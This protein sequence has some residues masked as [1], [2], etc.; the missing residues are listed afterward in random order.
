[1]SVKC[2]V[3]VPYVFT[4][5]SNRSVIHEGKKAVSVPYVFTS[6]SNLTDYNGDMLKVSVPYVFTSFSNIYGCMYKD[7]PFQ[8]HTFLHHSQTV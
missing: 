8:Y 1:M 3:S 6:F 4:S 5:F 7:K 2:I